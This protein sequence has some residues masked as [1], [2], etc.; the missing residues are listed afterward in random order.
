MNTIHAGIEA[1]II[2]E[3]CSGSDKAFLSGGSQSIQLT[4]VEVSQRVCS[5]IGAIIGREIDPDEPFLAAGLDS[6]SM[7]D[8][9]AELSRMFRVELPVTSLFDNPS[10][11]ALTHHVE[12]LLKPKDYLVANQ[13]SP[14]DIQE[15]TSSDSIE[16]VMSGFASAGGGNVDNGA[17]CE[18]SEVIPH[19]RW[20]V[21]AEPGQLL[22]HARFGAFLPTPDLFDTEFFGFCAAEAVWADPQQRLILDVVSVLD[23]NKTFNSSSHGVYVGIASRDYDLIL[24]IGFMTESS[25]SSTASSLAAT[26]TFPSVASGRASYVFDFTGPSI[27]FDTACSSSLVAVKAASFDVCHAYMS[28][29]IDGAITT[30]INVILSH[31]VTSAFQMAGMLSPSGRCRTLDM[32]ADGYVRAEECRG[33]T[34]KKLSLALNEFNLRNKLL[35]TNWVLLTGVSVNQDGR[36]SSPTAPHGPAQTATICSALSMAVV[37]NG[38]LRDLSLNKECGFP[39]PYFNARHRNTTGRSD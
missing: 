8:A 25:L 12:S 16:A 35:V 37:A 33:F 26:A 24:E 11:R 17:P 4:R 19:A 20:D 9:S 18:K 22:L 36:S 31:E 13:E 23:V 38:R 7:V 39:Y 34:L 10:A 6:L 1:S 14:K 32:G 30:G 21:E 28:T 3:A 29:A 15:F 5:C 27:A 2:S